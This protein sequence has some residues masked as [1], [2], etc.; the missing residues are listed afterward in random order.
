MEV[1]NGQKKRV[2]IFIDYE[3]L[4]YGLLDQH[5]VK[6]FDIGTVDRISQ[7]ASEYGQ[8]TKIDAF[9]DFECN[10]DLKKEMTRLRSKGVDPHHVTRVKE[11]S[12]T[13]FVMLDWIYRTVLEN[14]VDVFV[15]VT[16]DGHFAPCLGYIHNRLGREVIVIGVRGSVSSQL[17]DAASQVIQLPPLPAGGS[18]PGE[19]A[20]EEIMRNLIRLLDEGERRYP[21]IS[22]GKSVDVAVNRGLGSR[23]TLVYCL[24]RLMEEGAV[25]RFE[26]DHLGKTY[27]LIRLNRNHKLVQEAL[28]TY[29][30]ATS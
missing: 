13:D 17:H 12:Y 23:D 6:P 8:I 3:S 20:V 16:G 26:R 22:F 27:K 2:A 1:T 25:E 10:E 7:L 9:A 21:A 28:G 24:S 19:P 18:I 4:F 11:K 14:T 30:T 15:V 5:R 29:D